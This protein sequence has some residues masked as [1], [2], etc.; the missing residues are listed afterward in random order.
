MDKFTEIF[1]GENGTRLDVFASSVVD[2]SRSRAAKLMEDGKVTVNGV[3]LSK[4][5]KLKIGDEI[6]VIIPEPENPTPGTDKEEEKEENTDKPTNIP[7]T[8]G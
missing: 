3:A 7:T 5:T 4:N 6:T 8:N 2:I 1:S